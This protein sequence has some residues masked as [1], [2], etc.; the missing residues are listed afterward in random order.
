MYKWESGSNVGRSVV[1]KSLWAHGLQLARLLYPQN[2]PGKK[3]GV[4]CHAL[5]QVVFAPQD[6]I[7]FS[8]IGSG[9]LTPELPGK[10]RGTLICWTTNMLKDRLLALI[11]GFK[12]RSI[13]FILSQYLSAA[14]LTPLTPRCLRHFLIKTLTLEVHSSWES[15]WRGT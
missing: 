14:S 15:F 13:P 5:P 8:C 6:Q 2:S 11:A 7:H 10:A 12:R 1:S 4:G 3:T 9:F